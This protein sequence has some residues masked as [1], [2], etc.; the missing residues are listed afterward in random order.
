MYASPIP[1][2]LFSCSR[3]I[4]IF[5]KYAQDDAYE[6]CRFRF[7]HNLGDVDED[8]FVLWGFKHLGL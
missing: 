1:K 5:A 3:G 6:S 7:N 4:S 2:F 8:Y